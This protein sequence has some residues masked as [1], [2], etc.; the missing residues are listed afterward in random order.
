A[1]AV[2]LEQEHTI[3]H[4]KD[5][6]VTRLPPCLVASS[7][8]AISNPWPEQQGTVVNTISTSLQKLASRFDRASSM[9]DLP[10]GQRRLPKKKR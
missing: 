4:P 2:D 1:V 5:A 7:V 8:T 9:R 6:E 3:Q 10:P